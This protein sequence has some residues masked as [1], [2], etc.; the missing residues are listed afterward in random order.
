VRV[1][2]AETRI[3][4]LAQVHKPSNV[5]VDKRAKRL[6]VRRIEPYFL[7]VRISHVTA[8]LTFALS[9][10]ADVMASEGALLIGAAALERSV[11]RHPHLS[12]SA[13]GLHEGY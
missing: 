7:V 9:E 2:R 4:V 10:R 1:P 5:A 13:T 11:R 3:P 6:S 12:T 8:C